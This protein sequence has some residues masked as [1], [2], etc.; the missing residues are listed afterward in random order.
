VKP[1]LRQIVAMGGGGFSMEPRNL[2]LDRYIFALPRKANP[3]VCFVGTASGD[4]RDY[5]RRFHLAMKRHRCV[6]TELTLFRRD[7]RDLRK[8]ILDQDVIYVGGANTANLLAIWRLHGVDKII[9]DAWRR[10]VILAGVSAGMICWFQSSVTDSFGPHR[11]LD[12]GLGLLPGAACPHYDGEAQRRPTL[13]RLIRQRKL[14]NCLAADDGAA[15]HFIGR[16]M[17]RCI[18]S[19]PHAKVYDV[20]LERGKVMET[21]LPTDYLPAHLDHALLAR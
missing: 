10:G 14:P 11:E 5:I 18:A 6:P 12:D 15:I 21:A 9:R 4:S 19:R 8:F 20:R 2:R 7:G 13:H 16:K 1:P 17:H 3:K